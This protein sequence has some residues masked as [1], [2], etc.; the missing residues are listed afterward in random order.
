[1]TIDMSQFFE[2]F[3]EETSEHLAAMEALLLAI[4]VGDPPVDDLNAI[5]RAAHSIKGGSATFGFEDMAQVTHIL[6][7]LL[8]RLR[9]GELTLQAPMVDA[10]LAAVDVLRMQLA[11]H[12]S[13]AEVDRDAVS[14]VCD[15]LASLASD[16]AAQSGPAAHARAPRS[17]ADDRVDATA[18]PVRELVITVPRDDAQECDGEALARAHEYLATLGTLTIEHRDGNGSRLALVTAAD[19][20]AVLEAFAYCAAR[21]R[22]VVAP[23]SDAPAHLAALTDDP[24]SPGAPASALAP[25]AAPVP[26]PAPS[27]DDR[28]FGF[29]VDESTLPAARAVA[30][31]SRDDSAAPATPPAARAAP[32]VPSPG[33]DP[34]ASTPAAARAS[35]ASIRVG[36]EK[37]DQLINLVGELVITQAM[38]AQSAASAGAMHGR[39]Q[40][41]LQQ[42]ERN[43]RELQEAVM[44]IRMLPMS[45]VFNR[46]P[47]MVRDL[48]TKLGKQV[49]L[50]TFGE[51]TELDKGVIERI[52]DPLTHLV[53]NSLDHGIESPAQ[54]AAAGKDPKGTLTL[55]AFHRGGNVVIEV[56]DNGRGLD[57]ARILAKARERG[58]AVSDAMSDADVWA[59]VFAAGFSTAGAVTDVS[60]RG[61][62]MDVV[63]RNIESMGGRVEIDS[64]AD[65]GTTVRISLPLT[66]AIME[67][68]SVEVGDQTYIIPLAAIVES[69]EPSRIELQTVSGNAALVRVRGDY[70]PLIAL[71]EAFAIEPRSTDPRDGVLVVVDAEGSRA[72]LL[73]DA[74]IGQQQVVIKSLETNFRKVRGAS[75]ATI[76]GDGSVA[77]ILD[78]AEVVR[79]R[80]ATRVAPIAMEPGQR[81]AVPLSV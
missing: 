32:A 4:D 42:L 19:D 37:V 65:S 9:K 55:S 50:R 21:D 36:V 71:H 20:A 38:L 34:A 51:S 30:G 28:G 23:R 12:Q 72:A 35:E 62:G 75:A 27:G 6:E 80:R 60:G 49:E 22:V 46:F 63:K 7:G 47:R 41:R 43:T 18:A 79:M 14:A 57:R 24:P 15:R 73:V 31:A 48:S 77:L 81:H 70:L 44:G 58:L 16:E 1:M 5:F 69:L 29:F 13:G 59:L 66:L 53:R 56:A 54:R 2:V 17:G 3:F 76:M 25:V 52:T 64:V 40:E 45:F 39:M 78:V 67:G 8:D 11:G 10:F 74:L 33:T 68:M 26:V 61:V